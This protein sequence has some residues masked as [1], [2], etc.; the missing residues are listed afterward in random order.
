MSQFTLV[1][2]DMMTGKSFVLPHFPPN[3]REGPPWL[4]PGFNPRSKQC[5]AFQNLTSI[6]V[7]PWEP[8]SFVP[9]GRPTS[10]RTPVGPN[11]LGV[12]SWMLI[13]LKRDNQPEGGEV[14]GGDEVQQQEPDD[15]PEMEQPRQGR[16]L[17][18]QWF[19]THLR[20]FTQRRLEWPQLLRV[21]FEEQVGY[22]RNHG[23]PYVGQNVFINR[24]AQAL[25]Y[26]NYPNQGRED[27]SVYR[28][29]R[30]VHQHPDMQG[31]LM[32]GNERI[33][34]VTLQTPNQGNERSRRADL[35]GI[36]QDGSLVVFECKVASNSET[37]LS[38][39][40]EGLDYL[41]HLLVEQNFNRFQ[42]GLA[43]WRA[44][45]RIP[46]NLS[47]TPL[48]FEAVE[49]ILNG[50]RHSVVVLCLRAIT[51]LTN[52]TPKG[53]VKAGNT[54]RTERGRKIL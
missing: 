19:E 37:P 7:D 44:T 15:P 31:A 33:W 49:P 3:G 14:G 52:S 39:L 53:T 8:V 54:Y 4:W 24:D 23:E 34:L 5:Y 13:V 27:I 18:R 6:A 50:P 22:L 46:G 21:V 40:L 48:G 20:G 17:F 32:V 35:L 36:R 51:I 43:A 26:A 16:S 41:G 42:E 30:E 2:M 28:L 9:M 45:H 11:E 47:H 1:A 10:L 38:A 25:E 12:N 29:Y